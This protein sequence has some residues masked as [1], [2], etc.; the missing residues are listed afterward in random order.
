VRC[1]TLTQSTRRL[2]CGTHEG[3]AIRLFLDGIA[4]TDFLDLDS[5]PWRS[6][7]RNSIHPL[8]SHFPPAPSASHTA[9]RALHNSGSNMSLSTL[10]PHPHSPAL[11]PPLDDEVSPSAF[12]KALDAL[13]AITTDLTLPPGFTP[14][15]A[16]LDRFDALLRDAPSVSQDTISQLY[17]RLDEA[18]E[19][20]LRERELWT[21]ANASL[22]TASQAVEENL[23]AHNFVAREAGTEDS[24]H[25]HESVATRNCSSYSEGDLPTTPGFATELL[26]LDSSV[27]DGRLLKQAMAE[28]ANLSMAHSD[29]VNT[30]A[31]LRSHKSMSSL[32]QV[33]PSPYSG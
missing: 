32:R 17:S 19:E 1:S 13:N 28:H 33:G 24:S 5:L 7:S 9:V 6:P 26:L 23:T 31:H 20:V 15:E 2:R 12:E 29:P 22:D 18:R 10:T 16:T 27:N 3:Y 25:S 21:G 11:S 30:L 8:F 4:D 14:S